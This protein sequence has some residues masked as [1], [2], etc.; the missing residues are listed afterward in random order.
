M[1]LQKFGGR[2]VFFFFNTEKPIVSRIKK[3][4]IVGNIGREYRRAY[5]ALHRL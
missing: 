3:K 5:R 4:I 1:A 2:V